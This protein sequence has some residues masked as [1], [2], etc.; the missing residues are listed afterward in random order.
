[1][2][3]LVVLWNFPIINELTYN[4]SFDI[5]KQKKYYN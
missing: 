3:V 1:M 4:F 5:F 2:D